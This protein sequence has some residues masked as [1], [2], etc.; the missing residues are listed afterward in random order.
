MSSAT[1]ERNKLYHEV[2]C[3]LRELKSEVVNKVIRDGVSTALG[4]ENFIKNVEDLIN[5]DHQLEELQSQLLK[6]R[7]KRYRVKEIVEGLLGLEDDSETEDCPGGNNNQE[8]DGMGS[9]NSQEG[10]D[11]IGLHA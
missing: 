9:N 2:S 10:I 5:K 7:I 4:T 3:K 6:L 11:V 1:I 8:G